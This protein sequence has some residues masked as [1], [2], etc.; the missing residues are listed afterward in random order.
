MHAGSPLITFSST[1]TGAV[2]FL[3]FYLAQRRQGAV[4]RGFLLLQPRN[5]ALKAARQLRSLPRGRTGSRLL[6][7]LAAPGPGRIVARMR[8][9]NMRSQSGTTRRCLRAERTL[10]FLI[11]HFQS[12][13]SGCPSLRALCSVIDVCSAHGD[14]WI[15]PAGG[16]EPF[17]SRLAHR[18]VESGRNARR[19]RAI[20]PERLSTFYERRSDRFPSSAGRLR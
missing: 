10:Q 3:S 15:D 18:R 17:T 19:T 11:R 8:A 2:R 20:R 9:A 6:N 7:A 1:R 14:R 5:Y 16:E 4:N 13:L 12:R